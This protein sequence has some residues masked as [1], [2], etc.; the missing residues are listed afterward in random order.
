MPNLPLQGRL[1]LEISLTGQ[2]PV[3]RPA[4]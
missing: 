1:L 3:M 2:N 4:R